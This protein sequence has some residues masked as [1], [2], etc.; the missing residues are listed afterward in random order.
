LIA[1]LDTAYGI[2]LPVGRTPASD[3][4]FTITGLGLL[5]SSGRAARLR[6]QVPSRLT[7][8]MRWKISSV[9]PSRSACGISAVVPALLTTMS[10]RPKCSIA[11]A[12][13]RLQVVSSAT[14]PWT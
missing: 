9:T 3:V 13:R 10:S 5:R 8:R 12:T 1:A 11:A 2:E 4:T 6:Y 14:L 7:S